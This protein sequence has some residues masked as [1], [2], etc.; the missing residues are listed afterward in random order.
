ML[1]KLFFLTK[2]LSP[3]LHG[4]YSIGQ[5]LEKFY[6]HISHT[7]V[8]GN[9]KIAKRTTFYQDI[10]KIPSFLHVSANFPQKIFWRPFCFPYKSRPSWIGT[11]T[12]LWNWMHNKKV[13]GTVFFFKA[14]SLL[15]HVVYSI[16]CMLE[17]WLSVK[18]CMWPI[19]WPLV[20]CLIP[21]S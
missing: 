12:K 1:N 16:G 10:P 6:L 14:L 15:L 3:L 2:A 8:W 17:K 21:W 4:A 13:M 5:I 9:T 19:N 11:M 7:F 18:F 20:L